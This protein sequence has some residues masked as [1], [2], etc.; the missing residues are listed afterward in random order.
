MTKNDK[1]LHEIQNEAEM[2][3]YEID[4]MPVVHMHYGVQCGKININKKKFGIITNETPLQPNL[5][6]SR[7]R[8]CYE[9][10]V[11]LV[12]LLQSC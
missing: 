1:Y 7:A 11:H 5:H 2:K 8:G 12:L 9:I 3:T 6:L 10:T 4:K